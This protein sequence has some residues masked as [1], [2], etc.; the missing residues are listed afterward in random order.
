MSSLWTDTLFSFLVQTPC[1]LPAQ[2]HPHTRP[3]GGDSAR[4]PSSSTALWGWGSS[5][6]RAQLPL[7]G[8]Q[9]ASQTLTRFTGL[10]SN[11]STS[12]EASWAHPL[13][14]GPQVIAS[15]ASCYFFFPCHVQNHTFTSMWTWSWSCA[16]SMKAGT[17]AT[18]LRIV[19]PVPSP[20]PGTQHA[21]GRCRSEPRR[22]GSSG[23]HSGN[24]WKPG[25]WRLSPRETRLPVL[26]S[27]HRGTARSPLPSSLSPPG[28]PL[29]VPTWQ[30]PA[31]LLLLML[32]LLLV[33]TSPIPTGLEIG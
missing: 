12:R 20:R 17:V 29:A 33:V 19:S 15:H 18:L 10:C 2:P 1:L 24:L 8:T 11:V 23:L 14:Q 5:D 3:L 25:P 32:F 21:L 9:F 13:N 7:L 31:S 28:S 26:L 4:P 27:K 16:P 30:L 6:L 22:P